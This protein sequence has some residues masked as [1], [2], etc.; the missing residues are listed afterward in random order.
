MQLT[1]VI[2]YGTIFL[3]D[4]PHKFKEKYIIPRWWRQRRFPKLWT[5]APYCRES[6]KPYMQLINIPRRKDDLYSD[7]NAIYLFV[8]SVSV[9]FVMWHRMERDGN[10][11]LLVGKNR[12]GKNSSVFQ[13]T[14]PTF[15]WKDGKE[16][17]PQY[18]TS[19]Q[20]VLP[21]IFEPSTYRLQASRVTV[22]L[23]C[24]VDYLCKQ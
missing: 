1:S 15:T 11:L 4:Q 10:Y 24:S 21:P 9:T 7:R 13:G 2:K 8:N 14:P 17:T 6:F 20:S 3:D 5:S 19:S 23:V 16:T 22:F 12:D 18:L